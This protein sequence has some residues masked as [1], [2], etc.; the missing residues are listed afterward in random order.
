MAKT[1]MIWKISE[2]E[3]KEIIFRSDSYSQVLR[4]IGRKTGTGGGYRT[5]K[6]RVLFLEIDVSHFTGMANRCGGRGIQGKAKL[7]EVMIEKSTYSRGN[8][9]IRII[10]EGLIDSSKC[11]ICKNGNTWEGKPLVLVLDHINGINNDNRLENLRLICPNC[12]SQTETFCGKSKIG[13]SEIEKLIYCCEKCDRWLSRKSKTGLCRDCFL[14][15]GII[16][17]T[18]TRKVKVRP[19]QK[20]LVEQIEEYGYRG[21]GKIYGVSDNAIRKWMK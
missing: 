2:K 4:E 5:L 11:G 13:K 3:F 19:S 14:K 20:I 21:T 18:K 17:R 15:S 9:K 16:D 12:N 1:S 10:K 8:L 7:D 6:D